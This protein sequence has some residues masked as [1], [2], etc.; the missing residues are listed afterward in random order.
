[1]RPRNQ[2]ALYF[3]QLNGRKGP[4][5]IFFDQ[6]LLG[7]FSLVP[8]GV[9]GWILWSEGFSRNK[10]GYRVRTALRRDAA[11][12]KN[13]IHSY[14]LLT[15]RIFL[16]SSFWRTTLSTC[17]K[18]PPIYERPSFGRYLNKKYQHMLLCISTNICIS[19]QMWNFA[20]NLSYLFKQ[21]ISIFYHT[22]SQIIVTKYI[23]IRYTG[24][25]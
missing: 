7:F 19:C 18:W 1:M 5:V 23:L 12:I 2:Y 22:I 6:R 11:F 17:W 4:P 10:R 20:S 14:S 13:R 8:W 16:P 3:V 21:C 25:S 24:C 15:P 9:T